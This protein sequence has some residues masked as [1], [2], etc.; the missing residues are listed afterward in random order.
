[1]INTI[2]ETISS[3]SPSNIE[4][5]DSIQSNK[6]NINK[7]INEKLVFKKASC[8]YGRGCT[9]INDPLHLERFYHPPV[10]VLDRKYYIIHIIF[11]YLLTYLFILYLFLFFYK[12]L[13][14]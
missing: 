8:R 11:T 13:S 2:Q 4:W 6:N 7:P 3:M 10:P 5:E 12:Y 9:H 1:M 14:S